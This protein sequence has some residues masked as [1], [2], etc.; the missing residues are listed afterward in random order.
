MDSWN[1]PRN[2]SLNPDCTPEKEF[3]ECLGYQE[4]LFANAKKQANKIVQNCQIV[5]V[6]LGFVL[7]VVYILIKLI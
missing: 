1:K 4:G 3:Q 6:I 5:T 2:L 7:E